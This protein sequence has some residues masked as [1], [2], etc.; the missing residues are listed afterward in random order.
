MIVPASARKLEALEC[1][2][3]AHRAHNTTQKAISR[4]NLN[5]CNKNISSKSVKT[6][7]YRII[8]AFY[9]SVV[10]VFM[11]VNIGRRNKRL[12]RQGD[13]PRNDLIFSN[14]P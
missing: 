9:S 12:V 13:E 11:D 1:R 14:C 6:T 5:D 3:H 10:S 7:G 4:L 8:A 2:T